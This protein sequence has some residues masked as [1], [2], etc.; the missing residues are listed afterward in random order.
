MVFDNTGDYAKHV[1]IHSCLYECNMCKLRFKTDEKLKSH[2]EKLHKEGD[3]RPFSC[4]DCGARFKR[5]EHLR[6][7]QL[8]KHSN[9]KKFECTECPLKFRQRG[10]FNVHMR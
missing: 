1:K 7:H 5:M 2:I 3:D 4:D 10:E 8:Y 9:V 6:G